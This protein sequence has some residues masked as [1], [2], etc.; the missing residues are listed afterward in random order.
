MFIVCAS[1]LA[2]VVIHVM[3]ITKNNFFMGSAKN[4]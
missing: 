3:T 1:S 2:I 4:F